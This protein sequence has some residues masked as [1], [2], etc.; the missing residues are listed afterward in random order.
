M[1]IRTGSSDARATAYSSPLG[2]GGG[3]RVRP[4]RGR[5]IPLKNEGSG[6]LMVFRAMTFGTVRGVTSHARPTRR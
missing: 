4:F 3:G 2:G 5:E 1:G 6:A